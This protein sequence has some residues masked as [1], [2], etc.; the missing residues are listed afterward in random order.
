MSSAKASIKRAIAKVSD[1]S[2][3]VPTPELSMSNATKFVLVGLAFI[4]ARQI[5]IIIDEQTK[6]LLGYEKHGDDWLLSFPSIA[7]LA[8]DESAGMYVL[9]Y[10]NVVAFL[11]MGLFFWVLYRQGGAFR[12][13]GFGLMAYMTMFEIYELIYGTIIGRE[14][15]GTPALPPGFTPTKTGLPQLVIPY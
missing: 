3:Q 12:W 14:G 8:G 7:K 6:N 15:E 4:G 2:A 9:T 13:L 5:H 1:V 10:G 11:V